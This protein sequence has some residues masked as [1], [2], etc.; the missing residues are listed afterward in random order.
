MPESAQSSIPV[1][2]TKVPDLPYEVWVQI[3]SSGLVPAEGTEIRIELT[4]DGRPTIYQG[5]SLAV[6]LGVVPTKPPP[7]KLKKRNREAEMKAQKD[8]V[9]G[10]LASTNSAMKD[11]VN[12][13]LYRDNWFVFNQ[14]YSFEHPSLIDWFVE[15]VGQENAGRVSY[16]KVLL[17]A[18]DYQATDQQLEEE[19]VRW[20]K[21]TIA[22]AQ[23]LPN[24]RELS[25]VVMNQ[26]SV[27][28]PADDD[29]DSEEW[30]RFQRKVEQGSVRHILSVALS[31]AQNHPGLKLDARVLRRPADVVD[32]A[33]VSCPSYCVQRGVKLEEDGVTVMEEGYVEVPKEELDDVLPIGYDTAALKKPK[34]TLKSKLGLGQGLMGPTSS[35]VKDSDQTSEATS[36][37]NADE[38]DED[39]GDE[40]E[41]A[42]ED[43]E[44]GREESEV[45]EEEE[46]EEAEPQEEDVVDSGEE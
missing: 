11:M 8:H 33:Y 44:D 34:S 10:N 12:Q 28:D 17:W 19:Y 29:A 46:E 32:G 13:I 24:L 42:E 40:G 37:Q 18:D 2:A 4:P 23:A 31:L 5:D 9:I 21:E 25:M 36:T 20:M 35:A 6:D 38:E 22:I 15:L 27:V 43:V 39:V 1:E 7:R 41:A 16:V 14:T 30:N 26:P 3:A 45:D